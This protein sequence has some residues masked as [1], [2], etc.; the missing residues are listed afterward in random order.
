[1][2]VFSLIILA[3]SSFILS[4]IPVSAQVY[5]STTLIPDLSSVAASLMPTPLR[6]S[7]GIG[8]AIACMAW[9]FFNS[10][11]LSFRDAVS[12][13]KELFLDFGFNKQIVPLVGKVA[14][15]INLG[16]FLGLNIYLT[17]NAITPFKLGTQAGRVAFNCFNDQKI[18]CWIDQGRTFELLIATAL[19]YVI[20]RVIIEYITT[21]SRIFELLQQSEEKRMLE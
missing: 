9:I 15:I 7:I 21:Q 13:L 12:G 5:Q 19:L 18:S 1:M 20:T 16:I 6:V 4:V 2:K 3:I 8:I 17:W 11:E 14:N 10:E